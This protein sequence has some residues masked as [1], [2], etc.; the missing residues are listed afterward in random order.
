RA[1]GDALGNAV[2]VRIV[3]TLGQAVV[4]MR[5][6]DAADPRLVLEVALVRLARR[7]AGPP[8]VLLAERADRLERAPANGGGAGTGSRPAPPAA[9]R[10]SPAGSATT[11]DPPS[12]PSAPSA[13]STPR[14]TSKPALGAVRRNRSGDASA[15]VPPP[16]PAPQP[17]PA[18]DPPPGAAA[19]ASEGAP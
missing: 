10:P 7:D 15:A 1:T 4:D 16:E 19:P 11:A 5:G 3:E 9:A 12:A 8:L 2:L 14:A 18:A 17:P 6:I 13:P